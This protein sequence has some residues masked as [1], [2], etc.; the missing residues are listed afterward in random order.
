MKSTSYESKQSAHRFPSL[1]FPFQRN[2]Q[3]YPFFQIT[4]QNASKLNKVGVSIAD[5][6]GY[7][8]RKEIED[9]V[10]PEEGKES[11]KRVNSL[12]DSALD[13]LQS[14]KG[15]IY[16]SNGETNINPKEPESKSK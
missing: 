10:L 5:I 3:I 15:S 2:T 4:S 1:P 8:D 13:M 11:S 6:A 14:V 7:I 16:K 12:R 9:G